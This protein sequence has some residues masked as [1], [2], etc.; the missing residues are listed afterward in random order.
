MFYLPRQ[1]VLAITLFINISLFAQVQSDLDIKN[2]P[3]FGVWLT[4]V[5]LVRLEHPDSASQAFHD[6]FDYFI[7]NKDTLSAV[8]TLVQSAINYGHQVKYQSAYDNLWK[9]LFLADQMNNDQ[10]KIPVYI[11]LGRYY[12]FYKRQQ[13][14][15]EYLETALSLSKNL[16]KDGQE[17]KEQLASCYYALASTYRELKVSHKAKLYMDS[18]YLHWNIESN[19]PNLYYLKFEEG[20]IKSAEGEY[21]AALD[22][23]FAIQPWF[24]RYS[25]SFQVLLFTYV[26][27][28]FLALKKNPESRRLLSKSP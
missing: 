27:D 10:A 4:Q 8:N 1:L 3:S 19:N 12:S 6:A 26:G 23:M 18:C 22:T 2:F 16:I 20:F 28:F 14:S 25:P 24:E 11:Q 13:K 9:A 17:A 5:N 21:Q 15:L 7:E